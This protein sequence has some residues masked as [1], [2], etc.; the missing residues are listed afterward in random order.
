VSQLRQ[1]GEELEALGI[2][3]VIVTFEVDVLARGYAE[4]TGL[5]WPLL[6]DTDREVYRAHGMLDA[7]FWDVW[8]PPTWWAYLR[9]LREGASLTASV[10]DVRQRGG[11][12]LV[13]PDGVVRLR[14]VGRG[15]A[16]R[17]AV[18]T[19]LE[20]VRRGARA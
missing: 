7:G 19:L 16:D 1:Q 20:L 4:E 17:P 2:D 10:G 6:V 8:G 13:D 9:A 5:T 18:A 14:H 3:V 15:P 12:V 11:D